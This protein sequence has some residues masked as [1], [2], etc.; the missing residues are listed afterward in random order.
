MSRL[1]KFLL[2]SAL[3][4][5]ALACN[6]VTQPIDDAQNL[7]GTA[8][9]FA[10]A[11]PVE[12]LAAIASQIPVETFEALPSVIPS[13]IPE[14]EKYL[15]PQGTPVSEWNGI[16]IMS[17]AIAGQ[18]IDAQ[19]YSFKAFVSVQEAYDFYN[20]QMVNLG[21]SQSLGVPASDAGALLVLSKADTVLT[22]TITAVDDATVVVLVLP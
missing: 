6:M 5:F 15:D 7:A 17:Q 21:W 4:V 12:T 14:I 11:M 10:S 20:Q 1:S 2:V 18:E 3:V 9:A 16:P 13:G 19:T 22:V 8:Q